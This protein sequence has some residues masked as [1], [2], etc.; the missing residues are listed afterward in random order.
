MKIE[1]H[2]LP[3]SRVGLAHAAGGRAPYDVVLH[4]NTPDRHVVGYSISWTFLDAEGAVLDHQ[5]HGGL[6]GPAVT[7]SELVGGDDVPLL[8]PGEA[9]ALSLLPKAG[10]GFGI[11][12]G[13]AAT[14]AAEE[15][16]PD[17]ERLGEIIREEASRLDPARVVVSVDCILFF[18]GEWVGP[19]PDNEYES[20]T[21]MI[22]G[23]RR[24]ALALVDHV[25]RGGAAES[26][27]AALAADKDGS[28]ATSVIEMSR[29]GAEGMLAYMLQRNPAQAVAQ[30][31]AIA[32]EGPLALRRGGTE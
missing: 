30:A 14:R 27:G 2:A 1:L 29:R 21:L 28:T 9:L 19:D 26:Y 5:T 24:A 22:N 12:R 3:I 13:P 4:N 11:V 16:R 10:D 6:N 20:S 18:D 7:N 15:G 31:R 32:A 17:P 8:R 25:D 23:R